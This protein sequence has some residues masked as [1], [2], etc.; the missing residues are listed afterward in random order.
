[1]QVSPDWSRQGTPTE[2]EEY[3]GDEFKFNG[4][5]FY[6]TSTDTMLIMADVENSDWRQYWPVGTRF[7]MY[8]WNVPWNSTI[9]KAIA[10]APV[11]FDTR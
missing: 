3:V 8:V 6:L 7:S 5:G 1:M 2:L 10:V 4:P 9:F 11:R